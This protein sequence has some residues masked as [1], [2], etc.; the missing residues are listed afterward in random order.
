M[1]DKWRCKNISN[2]FFQLQA[3]ILYKNLELKE[4]HQETS[5]KKGNK[6]NREFSNYVPQRLN[7]FHKKRDVA[8]NC[9]YQMNSKE[10][11]F[12]SYF[13]DV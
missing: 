3:T 13:L 8:S 12:C 5:N 6:N 7:G 4:H 1:T 9:H 2:K 11:S 10:S